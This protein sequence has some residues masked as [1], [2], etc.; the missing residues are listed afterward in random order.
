MAKSSDLFINLL[1]IAVHYCGVHS[2]DHLCS[3]TT[4]IVS[5]SET[6]MDLIR[7]D[8]IIDKMAV[9]SVGTCM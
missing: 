2:E 5:V 6:V 3:D 4:Q 7:N 1:A 8:I 9:F